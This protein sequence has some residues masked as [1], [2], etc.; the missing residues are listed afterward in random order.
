MSRVPADSRRRALC[1][2]AQSP[3]QNSLRLVGISEEAG[4]AVTVSQSGQGARKACTHSP[5][6]TAVLQVLV[7]HVRPPGPSAQT[8]ISTRGATLVS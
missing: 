4:G 8:L 5:A 7:K 6:S 1:L 3:F 2:E